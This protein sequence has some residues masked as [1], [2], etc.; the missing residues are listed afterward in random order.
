MATFSVSVARALGVWVA[1][2]KDVA[3]R[4]RAGVA[5]ELIVALGVI[6]DNAVLVA[7]TVT[8]GDGVDA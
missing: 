2:S 1:T 6:E 4:L 5:D 3:V 8:V 7:V